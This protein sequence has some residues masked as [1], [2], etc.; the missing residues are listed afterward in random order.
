[1]S[2]AP[3]LIDLIH[4]LP[5]RQEVRWLDLSFLF[6]GKV[7]EQ[8]K[9]KPGEEAEGKWAAVDLDS[10]AMAAEVVRIHNEWLEEMK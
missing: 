10:A 1:M 8:I 9:R 6:P 7:I 2:N 5:L 4:K 3:E